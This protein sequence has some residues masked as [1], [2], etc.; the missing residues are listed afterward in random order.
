MRSK[1]ALL[2]TSL[3]V[4]AVFAGT[5]ACKKTTSSPNDTTGDNDAAVGAKDYFITKVFP[6]ISKTCGNC[7]GGQGTASTFLSTTAEQSYTL[8]T[9]TIGYIAEPSK[10]PLVQHVHAD[11]TIALTPEQ[12][13]VLT[14]WLNMEATARG[15][16]GS[17]QKA[18][19]LQAAYQAYA[20]CMNYDIWQYYRV[21]DLA[22][23][24]TDND[25]PCMGC[26]S[27]GQG[28][29]W[30]TADSNFTFEKAKEF[31]YIQK[32]VVGK[33]DKDGNFDSLI[34]AGRFADKADEPCPAG[35]TDCQPTFGLPPNVSNAIDNFVTTTLQNMESGTCKV[36]F[37]PPRDAGAPDADGGGK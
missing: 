2:L 33:V 29:A 25:G 22:F 26:H 14:Q 36:P 21:G 30:L 13:T 37:T 20:D 17:V 16:A 27:F 28:S 1:V 15:L 19:T 34:P 5:A 4:A 18:P 23:S 24:Q 32:M 35:K 3:S 11:Q 8:M 9:N 12:R 31:P 7:H 6:A 10:S